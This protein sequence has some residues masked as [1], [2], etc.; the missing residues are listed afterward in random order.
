MYLPEQAV[1]S[2]NYIR[3]LEAPWKYLKNL[4]YIEDGNRKI[5]A[6]K[7]KYLKIKDKYFEVEKSAFYNDDNIL[8]FL[9]I[10]YV[11][12]MLMYSD[13]SESWFMLSVAALRILA[14]YELKIRPP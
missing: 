9:V 10:Q 8:S 6:G 7:M 3:P 2:S 13:R 11:L 14:S 5:F 4:Q 12:I 1:H